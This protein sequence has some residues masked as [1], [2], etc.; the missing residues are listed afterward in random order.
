MG[1]NG[2][3][4]LRPYKDP[5]AG[6][7]INDRDRDERGLATSAGHQNPSP[8]YPVGWLPAL[9][10]LWCKSVVRI[11]RKMPLAAARV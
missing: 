9:P 5:I 2:H 6:L 3:E 1:E 8:P 4:C 10:P 11:V 7:L